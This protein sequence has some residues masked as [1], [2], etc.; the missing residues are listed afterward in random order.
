MAARWENIKAGSLLCEDL[1]R[2]THVVLLTIRA[3][4]AA[5]SWALD[6]KRQKSPGPVPHRCWARAT[7]TYLL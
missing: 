1:P 3:P 7:L 4:L 6:G 2:Q 5:Q